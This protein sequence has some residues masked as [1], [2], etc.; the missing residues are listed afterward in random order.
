MEFPLSIS[1]Y[2]SLQF[3]FPSR[4][5]AKPL[6]N[7]LSPGYI[8][9][10]LCSIWTIALSC[11][12]PYSTLMMYED[13][14]CTDDLKGN[15]FGSPTRTVVF[16][17]WQ[18]LIGMILPPCICAIV[19]L[20]IGL[21]LKKGEQNHE[22]NPAAYERIRKENKNII[23]MFGIVVLFFVVLTYPYSIFWFYVKYIFLSNLNPL[24]V[25]YLLTWNVGLSAV[26]ALNSCVNPLIYAR[27]HKEINRS[28]RRFC[29]RS[30]VGLGEES[31][32]RLSDDTTYPAVT[33]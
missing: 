25:S 26:T 27:M 19:Y 29:C 5:I 14:F 11:T 21:D 1:R 4:I 10:G 17:G 30:S 16:Y 18:T 12:I 31:M 22:N 2:I 24:D 3:L 20:F 13:G 23:K 7:E 8:A 9:L 28:L 6:S 33:K 32:T 15:T